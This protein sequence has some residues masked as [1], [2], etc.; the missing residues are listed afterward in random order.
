MFL[1]SLLSLFATAASAT[2]INSGSF[3]SVTNKVELNVSY[4]GGCSEHYFELKLNSACKETDPV[5]CELRLSHTVDEP[6][7]CE[8]YIT[9]ELVLELPEPM[10]T[11][12]YFERAFVRILNSDVSFQ[13]P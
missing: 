7:Y 2:T 4:G 10:L 6:D 13:L 3:N 8:G 1:M 11:D 9:E 5:Q 12:S